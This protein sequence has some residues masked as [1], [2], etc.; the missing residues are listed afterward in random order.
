MKLVDIYNDDYSLAGTMP[1]DLAQ[2]KGKWVRVSHLWIVNPKS[3]TILFQK[4][5]RGKKFFPGKLDITSAGHYTTGE[6]LSV[7]VREM[8]NEL[9][10]DINYDDLIPLG[11]RHNIIPT[12]E[13]V[14]RQFCHVFFLASERKVTDYA[15]NPETAEGLTTISIEE[16]LKLWSE[17]IS[18]IETSLL[19]TTSKKEN[20]IHITKDDFLPRVD[21][22]YYK[23]FILAKRFLAGEKH[24]VI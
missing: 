23:V 12:P 10:I 9:G 19:E 2:K 17:K 21:P 1:R 18:S 8:S 6:E 15:L 20:I 4:R 14:V 13:L 16:G 3:S 7:G 22:Y 11:V 5:S 24:L